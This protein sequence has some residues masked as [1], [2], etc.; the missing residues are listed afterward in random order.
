[1]YIKRDVIN[2]YILYVDYGLTNDLYMCLNT[3][4]LL[5]SGDGVTFFVLLLVVITTIGLR[6]K[7]FECRHHTLHH[8]TM[9]DRPR[10]GVPQGTH[11]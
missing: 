2:I 5:S 1:M 8:S 11:G 10:F 9:G 7:C 3:L 6:Y 4:L